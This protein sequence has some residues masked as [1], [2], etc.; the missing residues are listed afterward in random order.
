MQ[1]NNDEN[2]SDEKEKFVMLMKASPDCIKL[3]NLDN[4]IEYMSP[5]GLEEH[6]FKSLEEAI[7]F[8]WTKTVVPEQQ[9]E[10]R[11]IIA[12]SIKEKRPIGL[13]VKHLP[14]FANREWCHLIVNPVFDERGRIKYF[15]G[16]SRDISKRKETEEVLQKDTAE[17]DRMNQIMVGRELKMIELKKENAELKA[18]LERNRRENLG[19]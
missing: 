19:E 4:K 2:C 18:M 1:Q 12:Q 13:D 11:R 6:G 10:L 15:V 5:G 9:A 7:G 16:I 3:F 8:D 14:E 17:H